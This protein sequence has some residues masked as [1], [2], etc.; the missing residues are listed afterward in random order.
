MDDQAWFSTRALVVKGYIK[1]TCDGYWIF[2][3]NHG[4]LQ[5]W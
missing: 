3:Q 4:Y 5:N 1:I 2:K